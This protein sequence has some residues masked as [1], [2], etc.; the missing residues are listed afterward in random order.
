MNDTRDLTTYSASKL[1]ELIRSNV[2]SS[3]EVVKAHISRIKKVNPRRKLIY[4][5]PNLP[6]KEMIDKFDQPVLMEEAKTA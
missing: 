2:A 3:E 4:E 1:A 5:F 6:N